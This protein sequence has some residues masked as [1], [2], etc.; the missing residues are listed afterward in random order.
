MSVERHD[1]YMQYV[2]GLS[3]LTS[4]LFA[5]TLARSGY[6]FGELSAVAS[7]TFI[8]QARTAFEV[9]CENAEM[10]GEI[11]RLNRHSKELYQLVRESLAAL[12]SGTLGDDPAALSRIIIGARDYFP[13]EVPRDLA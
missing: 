5:T 7:T 6:A 9:V 11:Q 1:E 2:L 10:Y 12:E 8:K 13:A 3:H 4:I